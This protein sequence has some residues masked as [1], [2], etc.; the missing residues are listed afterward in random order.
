MTGIWNV[1]TNELL[2][3]PEECPIEEW[4]ICEDSE[5]KQIAVEKWQTFENEILKVDISI[6]I[7]LVTKFLVAITS[8]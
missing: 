6:G 3:L 2:Q 7:P 8:G 4:K 5:C 1:D